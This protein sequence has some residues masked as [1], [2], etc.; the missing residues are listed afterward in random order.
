MSGSVLAECAQA[1]VDALN[2]ADTF[3]QEFEA[4][5]SWADWDLPLEDQ[6][7]EREREQVRVDAVPFGD[8][9]IELE[10]PGTL[11]YRLTIDIAVRCR[12]G[13]ERRGP[14][15][16]FN[17]AELD[18]FALLTQE[19]VEFFAVN[20]IGDSEQFAWDST[21]GKITTFNVPKHLRENHQYTSII[22]V[23]FYAS[24]NV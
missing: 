24:V 1:A 15:G 8:I 3:S 22:R 9:T 2:E 4:E 21:D 10:T 5:R 18:A 13:P 16:R 7:S 14:N 12:L 20:R 17:N 11:K 23:P 19:I 6:P